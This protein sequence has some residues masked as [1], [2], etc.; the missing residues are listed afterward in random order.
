[1][2]ATCISTLVETTVPQFDSFKTQIFLN[3]TFVQNNLATVF[4]Y[5]ELWWDSLLCVICCDAIVDGKRGQS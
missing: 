4:V 1:M 2:Q 5:N 3:C